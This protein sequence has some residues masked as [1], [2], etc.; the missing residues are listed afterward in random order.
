MASEV[1]SLLLVRILQPCV[2]FNNNSS[3][4]RMENEE[5]RRNN[6]APKTASYHLSV[7]TTNPQCELGGRIAQA[8]KR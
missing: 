8:E 3:A 6:K 5:V 4:F 1:I 7:A 2:A